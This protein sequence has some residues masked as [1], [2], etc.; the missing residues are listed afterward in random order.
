MSGY[1]RSVIDNMWLYPRS[2][3]EA[4]LATTTVPYTRVGSVLTFQ[5]AADI[6]T[7]SGEIYT[8]TTAQNAPSEY[9]VIPGGLLRDLGRRI[10][11]T[12]SNGALYMI[13]TEMEL[14]TGPTFVEDAPAGAIGYQTTYFSRGNYVATNTDPVRVVRTG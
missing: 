5:N 9:R 13:W 3:I 8:S 4:V 6:H 1:F 2:N 11:F 10:T 14:L 12:L 7:L